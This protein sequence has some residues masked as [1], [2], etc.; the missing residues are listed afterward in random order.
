MNRPDDDLFVEAPQVF[1]AAAAATDD[2]HIEWRLKLVCKR[3]PAGNL[4]RGPFALHAGR[5]DDDLHA[6]KAA[7]GNLQEIENRRPGGTGHKADPPRK[8]RKRP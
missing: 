1:E 4:G 8:R 3:D 2:Q 5:N 7:S 6:M